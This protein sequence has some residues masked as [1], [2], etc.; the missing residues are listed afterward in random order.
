MTIEEIKRQAELYSALAKGKTIQIKDMSGEWHDVEPRKLD[1][2]PETIAFRI[3]PEAK[4]RPFETKEECWKEMLKHQPFGWLHDNFNDVN[5]Q[6]CFVSDGGAA[7]TGN[8]ILPYDELIERFT[9][10]DGSPFGIK[11]E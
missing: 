4:Y 5:V 8:A 9:F 1:C 2:F 10:I 7:L 11:E 3:K 6:L